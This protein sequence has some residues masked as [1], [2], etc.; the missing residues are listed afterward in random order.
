MV[1]DGEVSRRR[2][3]QGAAW[4]APA[5]LIAT[6][7]PAAAASTDPGLIALTG[8]NANIVTSWLTVNA[9][10]AWAGDPTN[11][12]VNPVVA[13]V[14]VP[15]SIVA[16]TTPTVGTGY[17]AYLDTSVEGAN[18]VFRFQYLGGAVTSAMSPTQP[19]QTQISRVGD[20]T[21]FDVTVRGDGTSLGNAVPQVTQTVTTTIGAEIVFNVVPPTQAQSNFMG[22][23]PAYVF[24]GQTRWNG[25]YFPTGAD[26][27]NLSLVARVP[28]ENSTGVLVI[29]DLGT[30]WALADGPV[31]VGGFWRVQFNHTGTIGSS[32]TTSGS[33]QFGLMAVGATP[34][35]NVGVVRVEGYTTPANSL[36]FAQAQGP[37]VLD[38]TVVTLEDPVDP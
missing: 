38:G 20:F 10:I 6:A 3:I 36:V 7:V 24:Y 22:N 25:P 29:G 35:L 14:V 12:E 8:V 19:L 37:T 32:N 5:I 30:G 11:A 27:T 1:A 15:T 4:S 21:A 2:V 33:L 34:T 23:G 16:S 31:E 9:S 18:T 26:V 13:S 28:V 17:W